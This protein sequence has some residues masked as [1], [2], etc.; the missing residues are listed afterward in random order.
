MGCRRGRNGL[1][2]GS[3]EGGEGV[4]AILTVQAGVCRQH[5]GAWAYLRG[6]VEQPAED[7]EDREGPLSF[8]G[9][10]IYRAAKRRIEVTPS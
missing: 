1:L 6:I 7:R 3:G 2:V 9:P 8:A 10:D 4:A 5:L